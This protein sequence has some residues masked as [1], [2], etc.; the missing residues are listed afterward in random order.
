MVFNYIQKYSLDILQKDYKDIVVELYQDKFLD[1]LIDSVSIDW[2]SCLDT[3]GLFVI[4]RLFKFSKLGDIYI[5]MAY[6]TS[7]QDQLEC[8]TLGELKD[9]YGKIQGVLNVNI[10][11]CTKMTGDLF[12]KADVYV[13]A[14]MQADKK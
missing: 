1:E 2:H 4:N 7:D 8:E 12:S 3:P 14:F 5:Q 13:K 6:Q 11:G 9:D 10:K